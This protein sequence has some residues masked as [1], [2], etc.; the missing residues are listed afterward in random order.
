MRFLP[1]YEHITFVGMEPNDQLQRFVL[2][3][4]DGVAESDQRWLAFDEQKQKEK[5]EAILELER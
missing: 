4:F 3:A 2:Q 5:A 1:E